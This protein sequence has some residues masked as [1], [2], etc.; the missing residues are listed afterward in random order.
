MTTLIA[1]IRSEATK[2]N[3]SAVMVLAGLAAL[4]AVAIGLHAFGLSA[5]ALGAGDQQRG[6][7]IDVGSNL[8]S[9]FAA[10]LGALVITTEFRTGTIRP[11]LL[12]SPRRQS[13][14]GAKVGIALTLG[15]LAGIIATGVATGVAIVGLD[16]RGIAIHL[17]AGDVARL[18]GGVAVGGALW[19]A[20][21]LAIGCIIRT[22]VPTVVGLFAW[23]LFVEN[24]LTDLPSIH[25]YAPTALVQAIAGSTRGG[26][27]TSALLAAALLVGYAVIAAL[28]GT[29]RFQRQ[30]VA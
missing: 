11:T 19:A 30:D 22:Q 5:S 8:G 27:L 6:I 12:A 13:V 15:A 7:L 24:I 1:Q 14:F 17:T 29:I 16:I 28:A 4:V 9:V 25:R 2:I 10:L 23:I 26:V 21:G 20:I 18:I 3:R